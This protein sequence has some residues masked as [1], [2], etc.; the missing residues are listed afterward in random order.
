MPFSPSSRTNCDNYNILS[1]RKRLIH[2]SNNEVT[3][4]SLSIYDQLRVFEESQELALIALCN[5]GR[6]WQTDMI[7]ILLYEVNIEE[8]KRIFF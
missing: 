3:N 7:N 1:L 6:H 5:Y 4:A 8:I 2:K